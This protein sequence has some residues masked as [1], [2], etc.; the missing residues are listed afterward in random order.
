M[1]VLEVNEINEK[2][3]ERWHRL[4]ISKFVHVSFLD[5]NKRNT[6]NGF[7]LQINDFEKKKKVFWFCHVVSHLCVKG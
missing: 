1:K 5:Y 3:K 2:T 6:T 4:M 7:F